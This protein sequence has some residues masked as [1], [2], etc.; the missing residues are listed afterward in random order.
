MAYQGVI[1]AC[2]ENSK[3]CLKVMQAAV[4]TFEE[5]LGQVEAEDLEVISEEMEAAVDRPELH[6]EHRSV[7]TVGSQEDRQMVNIWLYGPTDGGRSGPKEIKGS[8][9]SWSLQK[10]E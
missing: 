2:P 9:R 3:I 4:V 1:E 5:R 6:N 10:N 7:D 8:S